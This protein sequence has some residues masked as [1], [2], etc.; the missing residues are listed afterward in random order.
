MFYF[1]VIA[2]RCAEQK[3]H[4]RQPAAASRRSVHPIEKNEQRLFT[5]NRVPNYAK[6][7]FEEN[8]TEH[9]KIQTKN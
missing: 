1:N 3:G 2:F 7:F 9:P 5:E 4:L 6:R 8:R